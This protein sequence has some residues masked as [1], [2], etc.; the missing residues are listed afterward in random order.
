MEA[1]MI[2]RVLPAPVLQCCNRLHTH[3]KEKKARKCIA[4]LPGS[5]SHF[6]QRRAVGRG[7]YFSNPQTF[8]ST[9]QRTSSS[10]KRI[11]GAEINF[12]LAAS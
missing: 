8:Y 2:T 7:G 5:I 4:E 3:L 10:P 6:S 11:K 9:I 1:G 12:P